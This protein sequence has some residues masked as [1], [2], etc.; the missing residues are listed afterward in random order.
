MLCKE[1]MLS[2]FRSAHT[3]NV[4]G[5]LHKRFCRQ[6]R[7]HNGSTWQLCGAKAVLQHALGVGMQ[8]RTAMN[9]LVA[10]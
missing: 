8:E 7:A 4:S 9:M 1:M 2:G 6:T 10:V 5:Y 3:T